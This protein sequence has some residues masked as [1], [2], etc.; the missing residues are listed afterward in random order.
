VYDQKAMGK[1][2]PSSWGRGKGEGLFFKSVSWLK[3]EKLIHVLPTDFLED[4]KIP[5]RFRKRAA[6]QEKS[7]PPFALTM[8]EDSGILRLVPGSSMHEDQ[9][10]VEKTG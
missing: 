7:Q 5:S 8:M 6:R 3:S 4:P 9:R 1:R 10:F 2:I